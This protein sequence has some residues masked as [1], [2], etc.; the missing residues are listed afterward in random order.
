VITRRRVWEIVEAARPGDVASRRF[1]VFILLLIALNVVAVIAQSVPRV[2][3][4]LAGPL[5][6]FEAFSVAVFSVE[7]LARLWSCVE[8]PRFERPVRGRVHFAL[9][10]LPLIDLLAILPFFAP[11]ATIDLRSLRAARLFRL[12]RLLKATRYMAALRLLRR[13]LRAKREELV[14]TTALMAVLLIMASSVMYFAE[15]DAQPERFSSIPESMWWAVA[16][17]TTVGYGDVYPVTTVGRLAAGVIAILG[18]GFFALP[19]AI[20]GSGFVEAVQS[21][22]SPRVCPHCGEVIE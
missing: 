14:L 18:I 13:V 9:S 20:L 17:L 15:H 21:L 16:T 8:D 6:A 4:D 3:Q 10:P 19:T 2:E 22:K 1:D 12:V 11:F 7:Y 5:F